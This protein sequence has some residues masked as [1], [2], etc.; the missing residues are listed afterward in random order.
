MDALKFAAYIVIILAVLVPFT[1]MTSSKRLQLVASDD[2]EMAR[3]IQ[4]AHCR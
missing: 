1:F 4:P 2:Y 3:S